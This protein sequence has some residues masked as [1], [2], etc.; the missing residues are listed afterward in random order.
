MTAR[1]L[2]PLAF[3]L[4]MLGFGLRLDSTWQGT[5]NALLIGGGVLAAAAWRT[6]RASVPEADG[7]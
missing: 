2:R 3:L 1:E 7:R 4:L 6:A 5:A